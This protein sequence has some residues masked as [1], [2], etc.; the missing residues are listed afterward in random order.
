M[1]VSLLADKYKKSIPTIQN[2]LGHSA[3]NTTDRYIDNF[4]NVV[5]KSLLAWSASDGLNYFWRHEFSGDT[6]GLCP[7][8]QVAKYH[9]ETVFQKTG[10]NRSIESARFHCI[11]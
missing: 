2:L 4:Q 6:I 5:K 7:Y 1:F 11:R 3:P 9:E 8:S 10:K